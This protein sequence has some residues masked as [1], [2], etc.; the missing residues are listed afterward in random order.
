M[1]IESFGMTDVGCR[2][3]KNEDNFL[4]N[5]NLELYMVADGMGGH[6][7]GELASKIAVKTVEE[8]ITEL[9]ED[10]D[11]TLQDEIE[12]KPGD[13]KRWLQYSIVTASNRIFQKAVDDPA[14]QGMGT[15]AVA[16]LFRKNRIYVANVG[17][18]RG[19][20]I[21]GKKIEQLTTDHSLVGEQI[22]AG[23]IKP[24]EAKD[25]RLKN[26]ITRS[27]GFQDEVEV[28]VE[29]RSVKVGDIYMLCSD[30][31]YNLVE[32]DEIF[33]I[34]THHS[35]K[36]AS[37]HLIDIAKARGGDDNITV[38]LAKSI[39]LEDEETESED[40]ESTLQC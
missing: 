33:D 20:R 28:D 16:M 9:N 4:I 6:V 7:A 8:V 19:Y 11:A 25:H 22:R 12:I 13:F 40:E 18:S 29:A 23:M 17:D 10:P 30:G 3:E 1:R 36:E 31:L 21:R 24:K 15:T 37:A 2:R 27:V 5:D 26:I 34:I 38:I 32:D 14:L 35:L 39:S